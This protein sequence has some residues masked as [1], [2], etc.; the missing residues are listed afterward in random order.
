M[1][2][3][4][5]PLRQ[6]VYPE[7]SRLWVRGEMVRFRAIVL[8]LGASFGFLTCLLV[9]VVSIW[10]EQIINIVV[11]TAYADAAPIA[12]V[13]LSAVALLMASTTLLPAL[14]SMGAAGELSKVTLAATAVFFLIIV[15]LVTILGAIGA[16]LG[17]VVLNSI[18][19]IGWYL[20]FHGKIRR[21]SS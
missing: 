16:A 6:A 10:I 7:I 5:G 2:R 18:C 11:G 19:L 15:P 20:V 13:Q 21:V 9:F 12:I 1:A 8:G 4:N 17:H 3:L 14:L